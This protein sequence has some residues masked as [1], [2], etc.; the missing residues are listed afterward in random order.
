MRPEDA[1]KYEN[2]RFDRFFAIAFFCNSVFL[3][4]ESQALY[5]V[6]SAVPTNGR[7]EVTLKH[8][9]CLNFCSVVLNNSKN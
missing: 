3:L 8:L 1:Q 9:Q 7:V 4:F 5:F 6:I 2:H